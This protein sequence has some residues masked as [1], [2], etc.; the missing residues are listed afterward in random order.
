MS[1][2]PTSFVRLNG[3]PLTF[4]LDNFVIN[5]FG[6]P[7]LELSMPTCKI[8]FIQ[9][10][11]ENRIN[12][13]LSLATSTDTLFHKQGSRFKPLSQ[14]QKVVIVELGFLQLFL[15]WEDFLEH[16]FVRYMCGARTISGYAPVRYVQPPTMR[17]AQ[18]MILQLGRPYADWTNVEDVIA[19]AKLYFKNGEPYE[20]ALRPL[21]ADLGHMTVIRN[22]VAHRS[23]KSR[24][25]LEDVTRGLIGYVPRALT[26]GVL[27]K[28][29]VPGESQTFLEKYCGVVRVAAQRILPR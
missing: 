8:Q 15:A 2:M 18:S 19:L 12:S 6:T 7:F 3:Q 10:I 21:R 22:S 9:P 26:A 29:T 17:D 27:L 4:G 24:L 13:C 23:E 25:K 14:R 16:S 1:F 11:L 5:S 28:R 20:S